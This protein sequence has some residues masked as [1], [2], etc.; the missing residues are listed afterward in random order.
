MKNKDLKTG[1]MWDLEDKQVTV[2]MNL[3]A[4][5]SLKHL[6]TVLPL[7][8]FHTKGDRAEMQ[9]K[10]GGFFFLHSCLAQLE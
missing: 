5:I 8:V 3:S 7:L 4:I 10:G 2:D 9:R 6:F 1:I